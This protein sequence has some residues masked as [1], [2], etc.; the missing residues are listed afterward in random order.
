MR[1]YFMC[2]PPGGFGHAT[3]ST[4]EVRAQT[5]AEAS[6]MRGEVEHQRMPFGV[7]RENLNRRQI[8]GGLLA[9]QRPHD[10]ADHAAM[11]HDERALGIGT[12]LGLEEFQ[13]RPEPAFD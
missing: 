12:L 11:R 9:R 5:L 6:E 8:D 1:V 13:R 10:G 2:S 7:A 4:N 3:N